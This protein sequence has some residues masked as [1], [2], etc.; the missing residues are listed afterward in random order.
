[1][2]SAVGTRYLSLNDTLLAPDVLLLLAVGVSSVI[3][4]N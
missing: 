2:D 3:K 1:M 4:L